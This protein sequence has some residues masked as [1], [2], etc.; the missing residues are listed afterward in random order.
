M[1]AQAQLPGMDDISGISRL[2]ED[3]RPYRVPRL[4]LSV[5]PVVREALTIPKP[6]AAGAGP[7]GI[8]SP[9]RAAGCVM[10]F[11]RYKRKEH[12][13]TL[14]LDTK[15]RVQGYEIVSVGSLYASIVHPREIFCIPVRACAS[16]IILVHNHPSGDPSPSQEDLEVTRRLVEAGNILGIAVRDHII[17][18]DGCYFS[19]KEKGLM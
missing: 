7:Q 18:G 10:E 11:L 12:F 4:D 1:Q 16:S 14:L 15:N 8:T 2:E 9:Q 13:M 17:I 5:V 3:I 6:Y 19:Y